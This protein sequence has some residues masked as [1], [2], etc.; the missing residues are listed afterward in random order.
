MGEYRS[1]VLEEPCRPWEPVRRRK[2]SGGYLSLE[3][4]QSVELATPVVQDARG[5]RLRVLAVDDSPF[6]RKLLEHA[7]ADQ[8]YEVVFAKDGREALASISEFRPNILITDWILPD[9]SG[10]ELC[11]KIRSES[12]GRYTYV[13]L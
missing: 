1:N 5:V 9:L 3:A 8:P 2:P 13:I 6:S 11:R 4:K 12:I 10:P 7:L